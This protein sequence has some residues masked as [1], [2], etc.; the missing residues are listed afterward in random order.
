V[1]L[2]E[3]VADIADL[4]TFLG[5]LEDVADAHG[6]TVQAFDARYVVSRRHLARA[7]ELAARATDRGTAVARDPAVEMLLYAAGRRQI[8][9]ALAMGVS[10]GTDQPVVIVVDGGDEAA[11]AAEVQSLASLTPAETL[12]SV[13][14]ERVR[15]YFGVTDAELAAVDGD[16]ADVVV[17]RIALLDIEK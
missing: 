1:K 9:R 16:L 15:E 8:D 11:A 10:E 7:V 17:E 3:A 6:T 4:D 14:V 13:D 5:A 12:G 2:V